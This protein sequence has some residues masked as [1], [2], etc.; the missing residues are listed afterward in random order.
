MEHNTKPLFYFSDSSIANNQNC[1]TEYFAH[2][3]N[4]GLDPLK[5]AQLFFEASLMCSLIEH[6]TSLEK[7]NRKQNQPPLDL[8]Q[9]FFAEAPFVQ[10]YLDHQLSF[11]SQDPAKLIAVLQKLIRL[12]C[13]CLKP[14][15]ASFRKSFCIEVLKKMGDLFIRQDTLEGTLV[16]PN[17]IECTNLYRCFDLLDEIMTVNYQ[18][19]D[20]FTYKSEQRLYVG[21]GSGVQ[22][23]HSAILLTLKALALKPHSTFIDLGSGYGRVG[24]I[25]GLLN[26]KSTFIGYEFIEHRVQNSNACAQS[27]DL[28]DQVHFIC[29]DLSLFDFEIPLADCIYLYDPFSEES[30]K[31]LLEQIIRMSQLRPLKVVTKGNIKDLVATATAHLGWKPIRQFKVDNVCIFES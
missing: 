20:G 17:L 28:Q 13:E 24:L 1:A 2:A 15:S 9:L 16:G 21:A 3:F 14:Q 29:Q 19:E 30:F 27:L 5:L 7:R 25:G 12:V 23:G 26:P 22:S 6:Q 31:G 8:H 4:L 10:A 11:R 18:L